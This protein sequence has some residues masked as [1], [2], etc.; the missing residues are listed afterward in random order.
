MSI[1]VVNIEKIS[2]IF[3]HPG[4][5][6][7]ELAK[8]DGMDFTFIIPKD[9]YKV[10]DLVVYFPVDS[11][12]PEDVITKLGLTSKLHGAAKNRIK[13]IKLR[14]VISQGVV[15]K[16]TLFWPEISWKV[17]CDVKNILGVTKY[18]PESEILVA[19]GR[20]SAPPYLR[21]LPDSV[22]IYDIEG[23]D[24]YKNIVDTY[25]MDT[26]VYISE[27]VEGS[28]FAILLDA[29]DKITVCQ[30]KHS[31][32]PEGVE[33]LGRQHA[34]IEASKAQDFESVLR[35]MKVY[36]QEVKHEKVDTLVIRGELVGPKIQGNIYGLTDYAVYVFEIELNGKPVAYEPMFLELTKMFKVNVAPLMMYG[37]TL[38]DFLGSQTLQELSNGRSLIN[39]KVRRE[40]IVIKPCQEMYDEKFGRVIVK[41]RSPEYLANSDL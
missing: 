32:Q 7:L 5:D 30:R 40:G 27:K 41:M 8:L 18:E 6:R 19:G 14:G 16:P 21:P 10:D 4:A 25:L 38:K 1:F 22:S 17:G 37:W 29:N 15:A 20:G 28:H 24:R 11:V 36:L 13:T 35:E 26:R 31:I 2:E 3:P 9:E 34:W 39:D 23:A 12:L 33:E